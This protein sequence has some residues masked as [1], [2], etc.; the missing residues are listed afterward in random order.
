M[1]RII[2]FSINLFCLMYALSSCSADA[3][4]IAEHQSLIVQLPLNNKVITTLQEHLKACIESIISEELAGH[5][6]DKKVPIFFFK[7]RQAI[8]IYYLNDCNTKGQSMIFSG[9]DTLEKYSTPKDVSLTSDLSFFGEDAVGPQ[10]L[11]DLVM[12]INDP[13]KELTMLHNEMKK[14]AHTINED[15]KKGYALNMYDITKSERF[16]YLPHLSLGHLR[17]NYIKSLI[18]DQIIAQQIIERLKKRIMHAVENELKNLF[19]LESRT[20]VITHVNIYD[21]KKRD[22]VKSIQLK[23]C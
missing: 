1:K 5:A 3:P 23:Q 20:I 9:A 21:L 17:A 19:A 14:I 16:P 11:V 8:T 7:R 10:A 6:L 13:K 4:T 2:C 15:Y 22:Y 12:L 18:P